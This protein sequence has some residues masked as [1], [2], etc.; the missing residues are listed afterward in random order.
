MKKTIIILCVVTLSIPQV[1]SAVWW[2][3]ATWFENWTFRKKQPATEIILEKRTTEVIPKTDTKFEEKIQTKQTVKQQEV[4]KKA[5]EPSPTPVTSEKLV[6]VV[7][8]KSVDTTENDLPSLVEPADYTLTMRHSVD[9]LKVKELNIDGRKIV[10]TY[11]D[12]RFPDENYSKKICV[13]GGSPCLDAHSWAKMSVNGTM[14]ELALEDVVEVKF[15]DGLVLY[16]GAVDYKTI[17]V[18]NG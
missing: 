16:V 11:L 9:A 8:Y 5:P 17:L 14:I 4:V 1:V 3:P 18:K 7:S 2:N 13:Y 6:K 12:A 15:E 10:L